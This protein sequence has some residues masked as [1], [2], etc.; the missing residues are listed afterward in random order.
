MFLTVIKQYMCSRRQFMH[1]QFDMNS[2]STENMDQF[3]TCVSKKEKLIRLTI[4]NVCHS[5][6]ASIFSWK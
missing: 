1:K 4:G 2:T 3:V 6:C 5:K